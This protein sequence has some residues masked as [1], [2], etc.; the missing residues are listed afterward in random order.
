MLLPLF[1]LGGWA[2]CICCVSTF[3]SAYLGVNSILLTVTGFVVGLGLSFRSSTA[4]ER[5]AEGRRYWSQLVMAS[6]NLGR[7]FWV[8]ALE[9]EGQTEKD[10]LAKATAL[11]LIVA[12]AVALK[13]KLR[14]EPYT[15]YGDISN[16]VGHLDTFAG[17][18]TRED[19]GK[20]VPYKPGFFKNTGEY[21]G[22]SF[23]ASNP[24][25][26]I[27]K[28]NRPLGNLPLELLSYLASF[29]DEIISNGQLAIPMQQTLAYNNIAALNDVLTGTERVLTTPLPIAYA[30]AISQITWVYVFLLPF[31]LYPVLDWVTIPATIAA[32]YI[33]LGILFIGREIENPFGQDVNDLPLESYCAQIAAEM[34]VIASKPKPRNREWIETIDNKVLWPLSSS[35]WNVWMHRGESKLREALKAKSEIGFEE[36]KEMAEVTTA[37][38]TSGEVEKRKRQNV[39]VDNV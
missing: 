7:V 28:A 20:S 24:R 4:Y 39:N 36:R 30:I 10:V 2:T 12:F 35:G 9:R 3:T 27:K 8:H 14:Y 37:S 1:V 11:N 16:L 31:Q 6:Q 29:T 38:D 33:I 21:L 5:Y 13:H 32:A 26:A 19:P 17:S 18:A 15:G 22:V 23:A 25:K 34:D